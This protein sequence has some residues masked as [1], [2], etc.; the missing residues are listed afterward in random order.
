MSSTKGRRKKPTALKMLTGTLRANRVNPNEPRLDLCLPD[1]P[2]WVDGDKVSAQLFDEV[3][4]YISDMNIA[5]RVDGIGISLL[6]DQIA[7][8]L[9]LRE[10][11]LIEGDLI[12]TA[13]MHGEPVTKVHPG[14]SALNATF[15]QIHKMLREYGLTASSRASVNARIDSPES[16]NTFEDFLNG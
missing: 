9:R 16:T 12:T 3:S 13:N 14:L 2:S 4:H 1:R 6:S 10:R 8:Y 15:S 11:I 5:T 7:M